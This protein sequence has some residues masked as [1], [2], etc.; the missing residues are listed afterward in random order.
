MHQ[1]VK[2]VL[3]ELAGTMKP[4]TVPES[5]LKPLTTDSS[6]VVTKKGEQQIFP[7]TREFKNARLVDGHGR[8]FDKSIHVTDAAGNPIL[9]A[10]G[11]LR[12]KAGRP[13][14][15]EI[16]DKPRPA[17]NL[18]KNNN[19][20]TAVESGPSPAES[21]AGDVVPESTL[22]TQQ[23][24]QAA[25]LSA[26]LYEKGGVIIFSDKWRPENQAE[27]VCLVE[28]FDKY[29]ESNGVFD[30]PPGLALVI[31]LG[32]YGVKRAVTDEVTQSKLTAFKNWLIGRIF[33][34][35]LW[36]KRR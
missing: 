2:E 6:Q 36:C 30:I 14:L 25:E 24:K 22:Q 5:E 20:Q 28:A 35:W 4:A 26:G 31:A 27:H 34:I 17:L 3:E 9:T 23:R 32:A 7:A 13:R 19:P 10:G 16:S 15:S 18:P 11:N 1:P 21:Q 29:Y 12:R 8:H 33:K